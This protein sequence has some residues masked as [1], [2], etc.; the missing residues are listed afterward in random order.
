MKKAILI[1]AILLASASSAFAGWQTPVSV[2]NVNIEHTE[3]GPSVCMINTTGGL[4]GFFMDVDS[5]SQMV[6]L[7]SK[8]LVSGKKI[9]LWRLYTSTITFADLSNSVFS[10]PKVDGIAL[11]AN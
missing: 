4:W 5:A 8:A 9:Q 7:A 3:N 1:V 10:L 11:N 6:E 2:I